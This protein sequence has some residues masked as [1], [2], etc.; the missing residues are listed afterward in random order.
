MPV[1]AVSESIQ[2]VEGGDPS[3]PFSVRTVTSIEVSARPLG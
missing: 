3:T 2:I 1:T